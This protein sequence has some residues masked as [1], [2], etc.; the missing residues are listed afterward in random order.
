MDLI[1]NLRPPLS[2][3]QAP[4]KLSWTAVQPVAQQSAGLPSIHV[5]EGDIRGEGDD[6]SRIGADQPTARDRNIPRRLSVHQ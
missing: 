4:R 1:K 2:P 3:I 6:R 5:L